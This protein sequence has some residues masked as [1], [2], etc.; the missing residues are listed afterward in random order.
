MIIHV[1]HQL[2]ETLKAIVRKYIYRY[3]LTDLPSVPFHFA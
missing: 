3:P 2:I 1:Y